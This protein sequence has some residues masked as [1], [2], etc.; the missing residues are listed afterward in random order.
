M[1]N[2]RKIEE[3]KPKDAVYWATQGWEKKAQ[4]TRVNVRKVTCE[5]KNTW[6]ITCQTKHLKEITKI[7]FLIKTSTRVRKYK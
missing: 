6:K 1:G 5:W 4:N 3:M 7:S 2:I